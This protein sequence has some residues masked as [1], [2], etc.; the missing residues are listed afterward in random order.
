M[1]LELKG[2]IPPSSCSNIDEIRSQI[3]SLDKLVLKALGIRYQFVREI[4]K[5]KNKDY[6]S[7]KAQDRYDAVLK[8]GREW[9]VENG[10]DPDVI[11]KIYKELIHHFIDE[12]MKIINEKK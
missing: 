10:I 6:A 3:D 12:E 1:E 8:K 5:Y 7:I 2:I 4:V 9:A 11:E